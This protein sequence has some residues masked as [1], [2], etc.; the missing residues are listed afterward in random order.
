MIPSGFQIHPLRD[1]EGRVG[2]REEWY[3]Q[4]EV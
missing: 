3:I 2:V 1:G 4:T